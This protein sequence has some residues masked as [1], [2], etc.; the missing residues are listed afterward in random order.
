MEWGRD[1]DDHERLEVRAAERGRR[2][3]GVRGAPPSVSPRAR[4]PAQRRR[5]VARDGERYRADP[6]WLAGGDQRFVEGCARWVPPSDRKAQALILYQLIIN[7]NLE[8]LRC[9]LGA[10]SGDVAKAAR[11]IAS[12]GKLRW[13]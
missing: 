12:M 10:E 13:P 7:R 8:C 2:A 3:Q 5:R 6:S 1:R 9:V 4:R 11:L